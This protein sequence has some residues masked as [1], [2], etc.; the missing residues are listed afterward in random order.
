MLAFFNQYKS[1]YLTG[2][3]Y[4][5]VLSAL[6]LVLGVVVGYFINKARGSK[7][8]PISFLATAYIEII[9]GTPALVQLAIILN[10][11]SLLF[12]INVDRF[13]VGVIAIGLNSSAYVAEI[14][15]SGIQS[16]D[17]G[18]YEAGR[19]LGLNDRQTMKEIII[20]QAVK[21]I[22][23][24]LGNEFVTLIKE[25]AIVSTI[26]IHD[27]MYGANAAMTMSY[28]FQALIVAAVFYFILTFTLSK[29][30]GVV[31]RRME[32]AS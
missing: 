18:Q 1:L 14:I 11:P 12:G 20:P 15:R 17:K 7:L 10:G 13:L 2:I 22:L 24:A 6:S 32:H 16:V 28:K 3:G 19:S 4:T 26:G 30:L 25:T 31:E 29:V 8:K 23:P 27:L 5:I 21:N 9:R